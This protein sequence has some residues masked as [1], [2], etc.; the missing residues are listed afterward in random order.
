MRAGRQF[1]FA[2]AACLWSAA[3][4]GLQPA[5]AG[6][7]D[8]PSVAARAEDV[9]SID[10]IVK[11]YYDV[12]TGPPGKPREWS[13]DRTLYISDLRFV[14]MSVD[15][16]GQ[17]VARIQSHQQYVDGSDAQM[18]ARG[19][20]E[21]EIHRITQRFGNIAHVF[22]TY[23]TREKPGGPLI[24]RGINSIELFWDG[25]RWWIASAIW[26]DERP[27]NPLPKEYLP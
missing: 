9:G 17:P 12:I 16:Q 23:E 2:L 27:D 14:A 10:G 11:A 24:G 20:D 18:V 1:L 26:D 22:S 19:F 25:K 4:G 3:S 13:R 15:K 21:H 6:H 7:V 8:V 5:G